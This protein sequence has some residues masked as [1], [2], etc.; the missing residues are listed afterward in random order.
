MNDCRISLKFAALFVIGIAEREINVN[1]FT[2]IEPVGREQGFFMYF[3]DFKLV[4]CVSDKI[5]RVASVGK[6]FLD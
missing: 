6:S 5:I 1:F 4:D 3:R 2:P